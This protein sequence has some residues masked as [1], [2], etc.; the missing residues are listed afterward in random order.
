MQDDNLFEDS[1]KVQKIT[2]YRKLRLLR[3]WSLEEAAEQFAV[4]RRTLIDIELAR[5]DAP[6]WLVRKM[7]ATY[8]CHGEL[9]SYWLPR[10]SWGE[11]PPPT[12]WERVKAWF[13]RW[14]YGTDTTIG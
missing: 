1:N 13:R 4:S 14:I 9:I 5:K 3:G 12:W 11:P 10:F 7:D 8:G 6:K 2:P